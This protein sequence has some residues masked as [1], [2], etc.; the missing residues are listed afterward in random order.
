MRKR[1]TQDPADVLDY[2]IDWGEEWLDAGEKVTSSTWTVSPS[3]LTM[4][5]SSIVNND[6]TTVVWLSG[7]V[8]DR[9]YTVTNRITTSDSRTVE[10]S[11]SVVIRN[12]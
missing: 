1:Y 2:A 8:A 6:T 5:L 11:I 4:S 12:L 10:R 3:D 9:S 7:G